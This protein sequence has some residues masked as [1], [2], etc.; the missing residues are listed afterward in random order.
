VRYSVNIEIDRPADEVFSFL[1]DLRNELRWNPATKRIT[2]LTRGPVRTGTR[3]QA[4]W[5]GAPQALVDMVANDPPRA[6][7]THSRSLGM[8]IA[9]RGT[10]VP[11]GAGSA[12]TAEVSV[13][14]RGLGWLIAPI[15]I[16]AMRRQEAANL[17]RIKR[18]LEGDP[19]PATRRR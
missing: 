14:P 3:F 8:D 17:R 13:K 11:S 2:K 9:F 6:W 7:A 16:R 18:V 15:A 4:T 1:S 5:A 10:V 12:Y 19:R